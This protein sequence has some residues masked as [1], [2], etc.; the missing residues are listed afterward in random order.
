MRAAKQDH[1]K[2][3]WVR[4]FRGVRYDGRRVRMD[5]AVCPPYDVIGERLAARLRSFPY[6]AIH[7]ELP[8]GNGDRYRRA[9]ELWRAWSQKGV[10]AQDAAPCF[11]VVEQRFA[12]AGRRYVRTGLLA[13]LA[14]RRSGPRAVRRHEKSLSKPKADRL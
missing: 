14:L 2:M 10:L 13:A 1:Q 7:L 11:Y 5:R 6:N 9:R 12:Y 8:S 3:V 4:P